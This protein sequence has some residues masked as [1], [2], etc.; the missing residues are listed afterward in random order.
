MLKK[1]DLIRFETE[2]ADMYD[3]GE[4][5][6]M[7]HV[8]GGNED[9]LISIFKNI[10]KGDYIFSSHRTHYHYLLAGGSIE[11]LKKIV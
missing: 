5:I 6:S 9:E 8:C 1:E 11:D 4:I 7:L 10:K 2:I 3:N